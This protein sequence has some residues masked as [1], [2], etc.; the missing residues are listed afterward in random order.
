MNATELFRDGSLYLND[1]YLDYFPDTIFADEIGCFHFARRHETDVELTLIADE[2]YTALYTDE[3][4]NTWRGYLTD[5]DESYPEDSEPIY[6]T[7]IEPW[8]PAPNND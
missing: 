5:K 2:D 4:G 1:T 7:W 8:E 6:F 3:D